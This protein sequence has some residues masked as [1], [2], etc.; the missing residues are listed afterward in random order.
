M[1]EEKSSHILLNIFIFLVIFGV[2]LVL[3]AK[4]IG[5]NGLIVKEYRLE[6]EMLPANFS[7]LKV[8]HFSD[9]LYRSTIDRDDVDTLVERINIL[10]PDI[11]VFSGNLVS[12]TVKLSDSD[13]EF[14]KEK[15]N[16]IHANISKYY[17]YGEYDY[18][19]EEYETIMN[20][21]G[22]ILL[23]NSYDEIYYHEDEPIY[24][25]GLPASMKDTIDLDKSFDFYKDED[26]KYIMVVVH[27]GNTIKYLDESN[28]EVDLIMGGYSLNGSVVLPFYG[29][30]FKEKYAYKYSG[31]TYE[32][33]ITKIFISSGLGTKKYGY[34]FLNKPSFNLYR[35]KAQ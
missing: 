24:I 14:L 21:S 8:V 12:N 5:T 27:D 7:G 10:R 35:L 28:Y 9:L 22:F 2:L 25:V 30:L 31:E 16:G 15:L 3:Y 4:Y 19:L 26:R 13:I 33:G 29:G 11:V 18:D 17:I 32:K 34:R 23:S 20:D 6:S 1:E